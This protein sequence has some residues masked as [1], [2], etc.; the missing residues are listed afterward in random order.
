MPIQTQ[1]PP[2]G[3]SPLPLSV[4]DGGGGGLKPKPQLPKP[5][6][7]TGRLT[8]QQSRKNAREM[9]EL[10]RRVLARFQVDMEGTRDWREECVRAYNTYEGRQVDA[11]LQQ[12]FGKYR[13]ALNISRPRVD[14]KIGILTAGK[15]IPE[16]FGL[17]VEDERVIDPLKDI[18]QQSVDESQAGSKFQDAIADQTKVGLGIIEEGTVSWKKMPTIHGP[19]PG[20]LGLSVKSPLYF[21][22]DTGNR[23]PSFWGQQGANHYTFVDE[24]WQSH[25]ELLFPDNADDLA[26]MSDSIAK[27]PLAALSADYAVNGSGSRLVGFDRSEGGGGVK[28]DPADAGGSTKKDRKVRMLTH[29]YIE[30][31]VKETVYYYDPETSE[32]S[33]AVITETFEMPVTDALNQPMGTKLESRTRNMTTEDL[34]NLKGSGEGKANKNNYEVFRELVPNVRTCAVVGAKVL[35]DR[36]L[37]DRHGRW[38]HVFFSGTMFH[39]D[40]MPRGE[41]HQLIEAQKLFN[42]L[43]SILI[44][45]AIK[46]NAGGWIVEEGSMNVKNKKKL[47]EDA[48]EPGFVIDVKRGRSRGVTRVEPGS[49]SGGLTRV[50]DTLHGMFDELT[51]IYQAQRGASHYD[52]SGKSIVALQQAGD[53]ALDQLKRNIETALTE[54]ASM[55]LSNISQHYTWERAWRISDKLRDES[56]Y[57]ITKFAIPRDAF[58]GKRIGDTPTLHL[59]KLED[60]N[61]QPVEILK[62][63]SILQYDVRIRINTEHQRSEQDKLSMVQYLR[64]IE[65][66]DN[67][68]VLE[69]L[70]I[71][72]RKQ[73][74]ERMKENNETLQLGQTA[75]QWL[76]QAPDVAAVVRSALFSP[77]MLVQ[78]LRQAGIDPLTMGAQMQQNPEAFPNPSAAGGRPEMPGQAR[79]EVAGVPAPVQNAQQGVPEGEFALMQSPQ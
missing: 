36:P 5:K 32:P 21:Y 69:E 53:V 40:P 1:A 2:P 13:S 56:H 76:K 61:P 39:N 65:A 57:L 28:A 19:V 20:G 66:V 54:W 55:R 33:Q 3:A 77:Q 52:M 73:I 4:L 23:S 12:Q 6:E 49:V 71:S 45:N 75:Q 44:E 43:N 47:R 18:Y 48:S 64:S 62:D 16:I 46:V 68:W 31:G 7:S 25:L 24:A 34:K 14:T 79:Q 38:P 63:F 9:E 74:V 58:D 35:Y 17:G 29:Y 30:Y 37:P 22:P 72:G 70:G 10:G 60:G 59:Y 26:G 67:E 42:Q 50:L 51:N 27:N 15:P 11:D 78:L 8:R 41:I